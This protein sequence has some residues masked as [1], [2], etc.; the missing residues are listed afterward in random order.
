MASTDPQASTSAVF[1]SL[2]KLDLS[3]DILPLLTLTLSAPSFLDSVVKDDFSGTALYIIET[4]KD[5]T[6]IFRCDS[7]NV[8]GVARLQWPTTAKMASANTVALSGITVQMHG[9]RWR[10]TEDF[11][12]FGSLF[13]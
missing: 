2:R 13:T 1:P 10:P 7:D 12:K 6:G 8:H 9:G 11:M 4:H 5:R 3:T